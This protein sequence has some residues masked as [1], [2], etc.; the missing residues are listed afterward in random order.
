MSDQLFLNALL[1][2]HKNMFA[3]KFDPIMV[4]TPYL[5]LKKGFIVDNVDEEV[6]ILYVFCFV[7][8]FHC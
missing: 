4:L 1:F 3:D 2:F 7:Y 8:F 6:T 5:F